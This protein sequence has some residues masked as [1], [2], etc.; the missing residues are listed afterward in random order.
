M[1]LSLKKK[2]KN[3]TCNKAQINNWRRGKSVSHDVVVHPET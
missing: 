3:Q 1:N 2:K